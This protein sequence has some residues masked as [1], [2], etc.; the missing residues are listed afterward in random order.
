MMRAT[1]HLTEAETEPRERNQLILDHPAMTHNPYAW[2][3]GVKPHWVPDTFHTL[4]CLTLRMIR[5]GNLHT[6]HFM[7]LGTV[8]KGRIAR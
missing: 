4:S 3:H 5:A 1:L 7:A 2:H 8:Y 6:L